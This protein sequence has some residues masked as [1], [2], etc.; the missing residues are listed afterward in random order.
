MHIAIE[1]NEKQKQKTKNKNKNTKNKYFL[2][3][4]RCQMSL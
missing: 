2:K 1:T 4:T 3:K